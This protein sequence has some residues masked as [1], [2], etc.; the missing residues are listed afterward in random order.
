MKVIVEYDEVTEKYL[1]KYSTFIG[2]LTAYHCVIEIEKQYLIWLSKMVLCIEPDFDIELESCDEL[3]K[4]ENTKEVRSLIAFIGSFSTHHPIGLSYN[5]KTGILEKSREGRAVNAISCIKCHAANT[6]ITA[7]EYINCIRYLTEKA[8]VSHQK[9]IVY[10]RLNW[11]E[12]RHQEKQ[13][14]HKIIKE[15]L[16]TVNGELRIR[17]SL[18]DR[19][20]RQ[21]TSLYRD[22]FYR[23]IS[24][25]QGIYVLLNWGN[26]RPTEYYTEL[27]IKTINLCDTYTMLYG[28]KATFDDQTEALKSLVTAQY[29]MPILSYAPLEKQLIDLKK[30]YSIVPKELPFK[31][32][33]VYIG[34]IGVS[35]VDYTNQVLRTA[36]GKTRIACLWEQNEADEGTYYLKEQIN[37]ALDSEKPEELVPITD[38]IGTNTALLGIA[39]GKSAEYSGVATEAEFLV[40][41]INPAPE[42]IQ[43]IYGGTPYEHA[44]LM[45][46]VLIGLTKLMD[47]VKEDNKPTVFCIPF[48]GNIDMH[49]GSFILNQLMTILVGRPGM[50]IVIP[51]GEEADK[52]HHHTIL[53]RQQDVVR[54][55]IQVEQKNQNVIVT[56]CQKLP[57]ILTTVLSSPNQA[58]PRNINVRQA[59]I[60]YLND[61][62]TI[63]SNG[64][65]INFSNGAIQTMFRIENPQIGE[66][67]VDITMDPYLDNVI[68]MWISQQ[69]LNASATLNPYD[70]FITLGSTACVHGIVVGGYNEETMVV[71]RSS[72]RGFSWS[73]QIRPRYVTH[74]NAITTPWLLNEWVSATGTLVAAGIMAGTAAAIYNKTVAEAGVPLPNTLVMDSIIL[75]TIKQ[76][77]GV[78]Y[79]N[80]SQGGGIF[81]IRSLG[82]LLN[83]PLVF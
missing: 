62:T 53:A 30:P 20:L 55:I 49:D 69:E 45:P 35:G 39:G 31:G 41:K 14:V 63:Y 36:E 15:N 58:D 43:R 6:Q 48:N 27:G 22:V 34:I 76:I 78:S 3:I 47:F 38:T 77:E 68:D 54:T 9:L 42:E 64:Q 61:D 21:D 32:A 18:G 65:Y 25:E 83:T 12:K 46:D 1:G 82:I 40:A 67:H 17:K 37:Q 2:E 70:S 7:T 59:G 8:K 73:Y 16:K 66:W 13:L 57:S 71:L 56:I 44:V 11:T 19:A 26:N 10:E 52:K 28:P 5:M 50:S 75:R 33:G 24:R 81:D 29:Q 74:A 80:P 4:A 51:M 23:T 72:G 60:T 79:P